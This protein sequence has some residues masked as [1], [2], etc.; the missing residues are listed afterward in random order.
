MKV[1]GSSKI[2]QPDRILENGE[3]LMSLLQ[4]GVGIFAGLGIALLATPT[5]AQTQ[6]FSKVKIET[7]AVAD[8]VYMLVGEGGNIGVSVGDDG[9]FLI[10]DQFAPL[11]W[12]IRAAIGEL[13]KRP[14][15]F[16]LNTHWHFDHT[17][18]NENLGER[19]VVIVAHD[20]VRKRMSVGQFLKVFGREIPAAPD[21]ALPVV[22]FNDTATFHLNDQTIYAFHV[23]SAHTDG[24]TVIHFR[25]ADAIHAG[26]VYFNGI[27]PFIDTQNGGSLEGM[28]AAVDRILAIAGEET[29][30]IPGHG[31]LSNKAELQTYRQMLVAVRDRTQAAIR[32]GQSLEAFLASKPTAADLDPIWGK[33]FLSPEKFLTIVYTDLANPE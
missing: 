6:D 21:V 2:V 26:D 29:K 31:P 15:R 13:S 5:L 33:G 30:I 9:V 10:D 18:G 20:N 27:Y 14:I 17:G 25:E 32:Q 3:S 1:F 28:I 23:E 8:G 7:I 4:R 12:K 16:V 24:D 11:T 19:G 22:T